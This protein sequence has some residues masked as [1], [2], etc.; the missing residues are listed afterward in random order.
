MVAENSIGY[1]NCT[2]FNDLVVSLLKYIR[3][4]MLELL[5]LPLYTH[6][7]AEA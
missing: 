4:D 1:I 3:F 5:L 7:R 2:S 6:A